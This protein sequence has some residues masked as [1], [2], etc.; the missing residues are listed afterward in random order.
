M[1][2]RRTEPE[3]LAHIFNRLSDIGLLVGT[4]S[5]VVLL[6]GWQQEWPTAYTWTFPGVLGGTIAVSAR[7]VARRY[8]N[9]D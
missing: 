7:L 2:Y 4:L 8:T 3:L 6:I 5:L 9:T 1:R